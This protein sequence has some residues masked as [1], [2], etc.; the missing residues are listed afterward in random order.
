MGGKFNRNI[1][2]FFSSLFF[3]VKSAC[4]S[5]ITVVNSCFHKGRC[6]ECRPCCLSHCPFSSEERVL[7][8]S[9]SANFSPGFRWSGGIPSASS[10]S[11]LPVL[12]CFIQLEIVV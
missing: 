5:F 8:S 9:K 10:K 1:H 11:I 12:Y 7:L 6:S 4:L 3:C 2:F